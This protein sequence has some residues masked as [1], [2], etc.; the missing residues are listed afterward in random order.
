MLFRSTVETLPR[1]PRSPINSAMS[2]GHAAPTYGSF[3]DGD[4]QTLQQVLLVPPGLKFGGSLYS[5]ADDRMIITSLFRPSDRNWESEPNREMVVWEMASGRPLLRVPELAGRIWNATLSAN[6]RWLALATQIS[7]ELWDVASGN[8]VSF[9]KRHVDSA[10]LELRADYCCDLAFLPDGKHLIAAHGDWTALVWELPAETHR[11]SSHRMNERTWDDLASLD[12]RVGH[13]AVW[14]MWNEPANAVA[15]IREHLKPA[16]APSV[17]QL[18]AL[19][20]D[21]GSKEFVKREDA[22]MRLRGFGQTIEAS[23]RDAASRA[24]NPE[25]KRRLNQLLTDWQSVASRTPDEVR[26]IRCVQVLERI[27]FPEAKKLLRE[28]AQGEPTAILTREA[29]RALQ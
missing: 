8:R 18:A 16:R 23:V 22:Q 7:V 28:L 25:Q 1:I 9:H 21:L 19:I 17:K 10:F 29:Q 20:E 15:T 2:V 11:P 13:D 26:A 3:Y 14:A 4:G 27:T 12:A 24:T 5:C 6:G